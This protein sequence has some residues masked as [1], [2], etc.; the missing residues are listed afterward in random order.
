MEKNYTIGCTWFLQN[1]QGKFLMM[2][3]DDKLEI[4]YQNCWVFPGGTTEGDETPEEASTRELKEALGYYPPEMRKV[5]TLY[6]P[7]GNAEEHFYY[8]PLERKIGDLTLGEGQ[9]IELFDLKEIE[10]LRLGFWCREVIPILKRYLITRW[11]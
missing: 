6:Y 11:I 8:I 10:K 4:L 3:R 9:K 5:V 7:K 1:K 2:L